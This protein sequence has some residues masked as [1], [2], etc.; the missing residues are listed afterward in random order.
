MVEEDICVPASTMVPF[1]VAQQVDPTSKYHFFKFVTT[2]YIL[3]DGVILEPK[4]P[5]LEL[6]VGRYLMR[7]QDQLGK[8]PGKY[9]DGILDQSR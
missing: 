2:N 6:M 7:R 9:G 1:I 3:E 5:R 8:C 4:L